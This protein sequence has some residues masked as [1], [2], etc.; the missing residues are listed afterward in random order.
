MPDDAGGRGQSAGGRTRAGRT[1]VVACLLLP[2][3]CLL[4]HCAT[5]VRP[6]GGPPDTTPPQLVA[7]VPAE[8]ATNV[9]A[10]RLVLEFSERVDEASVGQ[11]LTVSPAFGTRPAVRVRGR[12][13]EVGFPDSLRP[14]TTYVVTLGRA[15][16]DAHGVALTA[17]ITLAFATGARLDRGRI[18]GTVRDPRANAGA[19]GLAV[20]AY[21]LA[22]STAALPD[23]RT[24]APDY[25][26]ETTAEGAFQL[27][28]LRAGPF[29]VVALDDR[30]RNAL[31]DPGEPFAVPPAPLTRAVEPEAPDTTAAAPDTVAVPLAPLGAPALD[32]F[33]TQLDTIPPAVRTTRARSARRFA[34]RFDEPVRLPAEVALADS[35]GGGAVPVEAAWVVAEELFVLAREAVGA[36]VRLSAAVADTSGNEADVRAVIAPSAA[37][38]TAAVRFAGFLPPGGEADSVFLLRP[39]AAPGVRFSQPLD[40][41]ALR[42]R[43]AVR[44]PEGPLPFTSETDDGVS[45]RLHPEGAPRAFRVEVQGPDTLFTRRYARPGPDALGGIVGRVASGGE[46]P[47]RVEAYPDGGGAPFATTAGPDGAFSLRNLPPGDYRLRL[48]LDRD[49]DGRWDGGRLAPYAP[50]EPLRWLPEPVRVRARWETELESGDLMIGPSDH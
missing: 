49:G 3:S 41:L 24:A 15:L 12:T 38:D 13:V 21:R 50:P 30:N 25:R 4:A 6:S 34:V 19:G 1:L 36:P 10:D 26:T 32:L 8:G 43:V 20:L 14:Q 48:V 18:A 35:A 31:A 22:D 28:Y 23:P 40:S 5:P 27:D 47:V 16:R 44:G 7:A 33:V 46:G 11:A 9:T 37:P 29:F 45:Y 39:D 17:P 2:A 42:A